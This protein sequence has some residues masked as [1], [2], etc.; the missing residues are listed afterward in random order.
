MTL[1]ARVG[2]KEYWILDPDTLDCEIYLNNGGS[3]EIAARV[4]IGSSDE[5]S[6]LSKDVS[7]DISRIKL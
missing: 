7:V 2:V 6:F 3:F 5:I 1:Y 4:N